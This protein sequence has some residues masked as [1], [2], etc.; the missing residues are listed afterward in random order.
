MDDIL[1]HG[2]FGGGIDP[3]EFLSSVFYM[4]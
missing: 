4:R 3:L 1:R 2:G